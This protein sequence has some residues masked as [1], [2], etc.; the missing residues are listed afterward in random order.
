MSVISVG[1]LISVYRLQHRALP[2]C[3]DAFHLPP[4]PPLWNV[5]A[6]PLVRDDPPVITYV[7]PGTATL[8][9]GGFVQV[10]LL[11]RRHAAE[12]LYIAPAPDEDEVPEVW[13]S[14]LAR[15]AN[16]AVEQSVMRI[17]AAVPADG[18]SAGSFCR[19]GYIRY[20][21]DTV[22]E[23]PAS[24][25][26]AG[27][28]LVLRPRQ[29]HDDWALSRLRAAATPLR[30]Q[31]A[32]GLAGQTDSDDARRSEHLVLENADGIQ[33]ELRL[34]RGRRRHWLR[35]QVRPGSE[36]SA[37][38]LVREALARLAR[39]S[40]KPVRCSVTNYQEGLSAA[41]LAS[42]FEPVADRALLVRHTVLPVRPALEET[43][44]RLPGALGN[45]RSTLP[46]PSSSMDRHRMVAATSSVIE[47]SNDR[48]TNN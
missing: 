39:R 32:E 48:S 46:E 19:N 35:L 4:H 7:S 20:A 25:G 29:P 47:W 17:L 41:L 30:V 36:E 3:P 21:G 9:G 43:V 6:T 15:V 31:Q 34:H 38:A 44:Q 18:P 40:A 16:W 45:G 5:I 22:Y 42:G 27:T 8:T 37:Q 11:L 13:D 24:P 33:A 23:R 28:G 2:L 14:L 12:M 10:R 26:P 1:N